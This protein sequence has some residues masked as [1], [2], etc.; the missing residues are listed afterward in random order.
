MFAIFCG[1]QRHEGEN[2]VQPM[3]SSLPFSLVMFRRNVIVVLINSCGALVCGEV[4]AREARV[5]GFL[6]FRSSALGALGF[7]VSVFAPTATH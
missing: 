1:K 2:D 5:A 4:P 6:G 7:F 3:R